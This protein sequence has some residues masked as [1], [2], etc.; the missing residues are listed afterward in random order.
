MDSEK[1]YDD[2]SDDEFFELLAEIE[3]DD[4]D[5]ADSEGEIAAEDDGMDGPGAAPDAEK[6]IDSGELEKVLADDT[7]ING[8]PRIKD[9]KLRIHREAFEQTVIPLSD[10]IDNAEIKMLISEL[11]KENTRMIDKYSRLI[12]ARL[13][14]LLS[15]LMPKGLKLFA[16]RYPNVVRKCP[17]FI[18]KVDGRKPLTFWA[19]PEVPYF[20]KQGTEQNILREQRA[21]FI[22]SVD[23]AVIA[24]HKNIEMRRERELKYASVIVRKNVYTYFDLLKVNPF[25]FEIIYRVKSSEQRLAEF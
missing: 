18:Y 17:G 19:S 16:G 22:P 2:L 15:S 6:E 20:F 5:M 21:E 13:T 11:V 12:N 7:A 3:S 24:F 10:K 25:W 14:K 4:D 8:P 9:E 1:K 23:N